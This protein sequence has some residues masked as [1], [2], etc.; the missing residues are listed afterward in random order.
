MH[1]GWDACTRCS[2]APPGAAE[3]FRSLLPYAFAVRS[4]IL[5]TLA[6]AVI[7][8]AGACA[9]SPAAS[10]DPSGTCAVDGSAPGAYP[11]LEAMVPTTFQD[12]APG[13]LDSGRKCTAEGLGTLGKAGFEEVR[14][15]GGTWGF[16]AIRAAALVV[17]SAPGL[18]ADQVAGFYSAS[19][20][21]SN[22]TRI[23]AQS[24][25]TLAGRPGHRLDTMTGERQQTVVVWPAAAPDVVN[26]VITNDLPDP[27][28]DAAVEAFGGR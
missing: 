17:F 1:H 8:G 3:A 28:I 16:G 19:A 20:L 14:F 11:E 25:P 26:V 18:T 2:G 27:K 4:P 23:T 24:T 12:A 6:I 5:A 7:L 9:A 13:T 21:T 22:R 15:A 10:F